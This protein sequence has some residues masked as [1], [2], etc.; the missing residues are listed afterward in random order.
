M[1]IPTRWVDVNKGDKEHVV[2]RSRAVAQEPRRVSTLAADDVANTFAATPPLEG[3]RSLISRMM[4]QSGNAEQV[5][6]FYDISRARFHSPV[7]RMIS[8]QPP[9]EDTEIRTGCARLRKAMCGTRDA[10]QCFDA[11]CEATMKQLGFRVGDFSPC[12]HY[13]KE[14]NIACYR[15]GDDFVPL[16]T[17]EAQ[18]WFHQALNKH[19]ICKHSGTLGP[20]KAKG[21]VQETQCLNRL[22]RFVQPP[23]KGEGAS[24]VE[25]ELDPRHVEILLAAVNLKENSRPLGTPGIKPPKGSD[26]SILGPGD[27]ATYR[28]VTMG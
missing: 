22:I 20:S 16:G 12:L 24:Y 9:R 4:S 21:D 10:A 8:I 23:F 26:E 3:F 27:R 1:V 18:L 2:I 28:P 17:R 14:R 7:R 15:H 11:F 6:G 13:H 5:L 19:M 25:W